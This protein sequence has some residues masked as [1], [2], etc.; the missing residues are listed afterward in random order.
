MTLKH[1]IGAERVSPAKLGSVESS[2]EP[3]PIDTRSSS[4]QNWLHRVTAAR[5]FLC[6]CL[7][8][9]SSFLPPSGSLDS[10][11]RL[12]G[13]YK[14]LD[15]VVGLS[16]SISGSHVRSEAPSEKNRARTTRVWGVVRTRVSEPSKHSDRSRKGTRKVDKSFSGSPA[17][18]E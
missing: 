12:N 6:Q 1:V 2:V 16:R 10:V 18:S 3:A 15:G 4:R 7:A 11:D 13:D 14:T 8:F 5:I 9:Y 17:V